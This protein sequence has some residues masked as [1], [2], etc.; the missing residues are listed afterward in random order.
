[1]RRIGMV[2]FLALVATIVSC[3]SPL[4]SQQEKGAK[5]KHALDVPYEPTSYGIAEAMLS[6]AEVTAK[7]LVYDLGCGDGRI[8]ILAAK[9]RG[10]SGVGV[11]ID[12]VRIKE[13]RE[14]AKAAGISD[15]VRFFQQ[16]LFDTD[17][18]G[19]TVV[20]LYLWPEVNLRLRPKLLRELKSGTRIVSHSHTMGDWEADGTRTV[21]KHDLRLFIVPVNVTGT[22][23]W[24][25]GE[26]GRTALRLKQKFQKVE[27]S[28]LTDGGNEPITDCTLRGNVLRFST[29]RIS[30]GEKGVLFFE[31][32]VWDNEMEGRITQGTGGGP[33]SQWKARR[34]AST[35]VSIVH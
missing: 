5:G 10:A 6:M 3:A 16:N 20:M 28:L 12:P 35:V 8:V 22:W 26:G 25:G 27:G 33:V 7:D 31:G 11:D 2:L 19:A 23:L 13:S 9:E 34:D 18:T 15:R 24:T 17:I 14:N 32:R 21:E 1:M 4:Y 29:E 30:K